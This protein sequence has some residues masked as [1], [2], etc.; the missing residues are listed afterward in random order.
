MLTGFFDM[1]PIYTADDR[2]YC[3]DVQKHAC[4]LIHPSE[5]QVKPQIRNMAKAIRQPVDQCK[6]NERNTDKHCF[7]Q[8][9]PSA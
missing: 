5:N 2:H 1:E 7:L 9:L 6:C 8:F 3:K 4:Q